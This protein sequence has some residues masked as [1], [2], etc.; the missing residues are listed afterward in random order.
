MSTADNLAELLNSNEN[1]P[2]NEDI[3]NSEQMSY[4]S[5]SE[6]D[7]VLDEHLTDD[8]ENF[9]HEQLIAHCA[10][11]DDSRPAIMPTDQLR[12]AQLL[13]FEEAFR[14]KHHWD[15]TT[16]TYKNDAYRTRCEMCASE[17]PNPP[18]RWCCQYCN[19]ENFPLKIVCSNCTEIRKWQNF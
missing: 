5:E 8:Y 9:I 6:T 2:T 16:C 19:A 12:A 15:C 3:D 17:H 14:K 18:T 7:G 4:S 1:Q 10:S 13:V 11:D